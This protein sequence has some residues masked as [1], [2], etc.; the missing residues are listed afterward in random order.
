M[1]LK[2]N[3]FTIK[4]QDITD[5]K[6][7]FRIKLNADSFI[8]QAHFPQNPITPGVCL[9]QIVMELFGSLKGEKFNIKTLKNVKFTAPINPLE[10]S[11]VDFSLDFSE[12][13]NS[14][15]IKA[16][17]KENETVFAKISMV[18]V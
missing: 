15:Q 4:N 11:E 7:D 5:S 12:N 1:I 8:Y 3:F 13:E 9:I 14:W 18:L 6:A 16:L 10:F 17:V 2:D